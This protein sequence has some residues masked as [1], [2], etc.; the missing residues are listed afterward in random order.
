M[1]K[2]FKIGFT[3]GTFDMFHIGHLNLLRNAKEQCE[4]L[5]VGVNSDELVKIYK[6]KTPVIRANE[7]AEIIREL[8]CV[9]DVIITNTLDKLHTWN[10]LKYDVIFIGDDW[11]GNERWE[12]TEREL[13]NVGAKVV[14]LKHTEGISSTLLRDK[15]DTKVTE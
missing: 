15:E 12:K 11:K 2:K 13:S 7:R 14:Y 3:Q 4:L 1:N 6:N 10:T 8:R 9:D 5:I